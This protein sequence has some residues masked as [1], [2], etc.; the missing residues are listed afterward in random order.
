MR[1]LCECSEDFVEVN[2]ADGLEEGIL[3][4]L[5]LAMLS[6]CVLVLMGRRRRISDLHFLD[7]LGNVDIGDLSIRGR[8]RSKRCQ[9]H[10]FR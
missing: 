4:L 3:T 8:K 6:L 1:V 2:L 9:K 10:A 5:I 7:P